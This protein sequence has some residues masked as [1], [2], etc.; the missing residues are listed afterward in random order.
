MAKKKKKKLRTGRL[1]LF[2]VLVL[3]IIALVGAVLFL[4][5]RDRT[6][7]SGDSTEA[8]T[9]A[10][11]QLDYE[12][13]V[14]TSGDGFQAKVDEMYSKAAEG[15][16]SLEYKSDITSKDGENF[17]CYIANS[18]QNRYDMFVAIYTDDDLTDEVYLSGL[19]PIGSAMSSF[20]SEQKLSPGVY[21]GTIVM[22]QV[23]SDN[24]TM[25]SQV[26]YAVNISVQY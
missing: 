8:T 20:K 17:T 1:V 5:L 9:E 6:G 24:A 19:I 25:H 11:K 7:S 22:T 26:K 13:G 16:A 23:E 21:S 18:V 12:G 15:Y 10:S 3:L 14:V 4:L 2:I